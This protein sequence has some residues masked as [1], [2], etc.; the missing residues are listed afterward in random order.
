MTEFIS[1][2]PV[3]LTY[4]L[5]DESG[6]PTDDFTGIELHIR[7]YDGSVDYEFYY[8][9]ELDKS[10]EIS[11]TGTGA[12]KFVSSALAAAGQYWA[13]WQANGG[14]LPERSNSPS[15]RVIAAQS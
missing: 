4:T 9:T 8:N 3:T 7:N 10:D 15:F 13:Q 2:E 14:T 12:F 6:D 1:G 5:T 11:K